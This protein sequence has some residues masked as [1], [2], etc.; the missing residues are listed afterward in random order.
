MYKGISV[1]ERKITG[2]FTCMMKQVENSK[3]IS[4]EISKNETGLKA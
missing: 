2:S 4:E 1:C 3:L